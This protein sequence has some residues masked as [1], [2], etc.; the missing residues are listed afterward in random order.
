MAGL[1]PT[2]FL[3]VLLLLPLPISLSRHAPDTTALDVINAIHNTLAVL[4]SSSP[5][6]TATDFLAFSL[7]SR[8]SISPDRHEDYRAL[9]LARLERDEERVR[10]LNVKLNL[11]VRGVRNA[12]LVP[13][14][15]HE[16]QEEPFVSGVLPG[17]GEYLSRVGVGRPAK[18]MYMVLDTGSDV[19]W[20]L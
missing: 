19:T 20:V 11:A 9:T 1:L 4:N 5:P 12:D 13:L 7:H 14:Q 3:L 15:S 16:K 2:G 8:D 17:F 18:P 6:T 10:A